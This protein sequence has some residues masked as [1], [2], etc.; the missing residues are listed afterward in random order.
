[1]TADSHTRVGGVPGRLAAM[2]VTAVLR[3]SGQWQA[4]TS[5]PIILGYQN[6]IRA[7]GQVNHEGD[8]ARVP[9]DQRDI[10]FYGDGITAVM[11]KV[12][13][14]QVVYI[15]ALSAVHGYNLRQ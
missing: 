7:E 15:P 10:D 5:H 14:C 2:V 11:V 9:V 12:D 1:M 13:R 6:L 3:L 8:K 4:T